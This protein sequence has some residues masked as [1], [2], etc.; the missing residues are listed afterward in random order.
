MKELAHHYDNTRNRFPRDRLIIL[1]D[2]DGTIIDM[3]HV[4]LHVLK[5]CDAAFGTTRFRDL[6]VEDV[7]VHEEQVG[8]LLAR[9]AIPPEER[10]RLLGRFEEMLWQSAIAI[11]GHEPFPGVFDV[12]KWFQD[13]PRTFVGLN[14][15]RPEVLREVTLT[16]VN[17]LGTAHGVSFPDSHLFMRPPDLDGN[18][19]QGK[20]EGVRH[21]TGRGYR[22]FAMIDNEPENLQILAEEDKDREILLLHADTIFKSPCHIMPRRSVRGKTYDLTRLKSEWEKIRGKWSG[23][24][25]GFTNPMEVP[26]SS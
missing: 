18:I 15:G 5:R 23:K 14:T 9:M 19:R 17:R 3:R 10:R 8:D 25:P 12:I 20:V 26:A 16:A 24:V 6:T 13:Q 21:F 7:D 22:V 11:E 2:I 1:F 4:I